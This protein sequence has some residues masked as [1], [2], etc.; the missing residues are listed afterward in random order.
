MKRILSILAVSFLMIGMV[1]CDIIDE[2]DYNKEGGGDLIQVAVQK[3]VL[4]EDYTGVRC[5]NCPAAGEMALE[6]QKQ[7]GHNVIVL[8]V[9]SGFLSAPIG[10]YPNFKTKEG[11]EWYNFF[12]FDS[13]PIGTINRKF[14][15][16]SYAFNSPEWGD[17]IAATLQEEA[18]VEM[19]PIVNYD[20]SNRELEINVFSKFLTEMIDTTYRL[21]V[22][23]M[24]DSIVGKQL[25][26]DGDD[27]DYVHRHV[28]RET[29]NGTWGES[30]N[31]TDENPL[32]IAPKEM[33]IKS[34]SVKLNETY[35]ADQCYVIAYVANG[36][37]KEVLQ[38]IEKKIK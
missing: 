8:G 32:V 29:I 31:G 11:D 1:A 37:T 38:V 30:L 25:T 27:L 35:N 33:I 9:H 14:N 6:L 13:N 24:E 18:V 22:C 2:Q 34:Y 21:T 7:Y 5:T 4:L 20:E 10:G 26:P 16:G 12:G 17:A 3:N 15:S 28:F 19:T 36:E 23:I